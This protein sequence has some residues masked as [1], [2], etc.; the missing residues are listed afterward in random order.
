M[1]GLSSF[2]PLLVVFH[3]GT[4]LGSDLCHCALCDGLDTG[5]HEMASPYQSADGGTSVHL[6]GLNVLAIVILL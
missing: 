2:D 5:M 1:Q 4:Y 3:T 6:H